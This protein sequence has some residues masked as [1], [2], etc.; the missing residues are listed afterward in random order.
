MACALLLVLTGCQT[1]TPPP[2]TSAEVVGECRPGSG[3]LRGYLDPKA[4]PDS[5]ALLPGPPVNESAAPA[6]GQG[7][8]DLLK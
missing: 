8:A 4:L 1:P 2:P 3:Y 5:L 7:L 6:A